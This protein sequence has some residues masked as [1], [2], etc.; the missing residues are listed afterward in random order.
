MLFRSRR[1]LVDT[2]IVQSFI[3][4]EL[5]PVVAAGGHAMLLSA[6]SSYDPAAV[7]AAGIRYLGLSAALPADLVAPAS[8][9]GLDVAVWVL[10]RRVDLTRWLAAGVAGFFSDDPLYVSGRSP[11]SRSDPFRLRTFGHG[12]LAS[13]VAGDRG[14][15]WPG[16]AW[17]YAGTG[18]EYRG[19]LQGW[20]G[21]LTDDRFGITLTIRIDAAA[22]A[23]GWAGVF[24][25][26]ADDRSFDDLDRHRPGLCGYH[27][28]LHQSGELEVR[29]VD[30]GISRRVACAASPALP[31]G[32]T[33]TIRVQVAPAELAVTRLDTAD[34]PAA[35]TVADGTHR[36]GYLHLGRRRAAVRF[37]D[38]GIDQEA[39][40]AHHRR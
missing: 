17:G 1:G 4:S 36:G 2:A 40:H 15:F 6:T 12:H 28:M 11:V 23:D 27:V 10:D 30:D 33:A 24:V 34:P 31:P 21:R 16:G 37:S 32:G 5:D 19:A 3:R 39:P 18:E 13:A 26:A 29:I 8:A 9:A 22:D 35:V 7:R 25:C 14:T 20:A 38:L